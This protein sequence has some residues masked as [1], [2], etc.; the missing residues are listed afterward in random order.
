MAT[1][2]N[3]SRRTFINKIGTAIGGIYAFTS[4]LINPFKSWADNKGINSKTKVAATLADNYERTFIKQKV[5]HLFDSLG[6]ISDIIKPGFKVGIK[7]N[8]T[9]GSDWDGHANLQGVDIRECTWTHPEILRA[10]GELLLENG[11]S[12]EDIY[13]VEAIWDM[14]SYDLYGYKD[15]QEELGAQLVN[16]NNPDPYSDFM[17]KSTGTDYFF[18]PSLKLNKTL[19]ELEVFV[20]IPKMKQHYDA[21]LTHSM[22]NLVGIVPMHLY[23][24]PDNQGWRSKLHFEGGPVGQHLPSSICDLN[25]ARPIHLSVIDGIKNAV[26]GE[27]PW[28]DTFEPAEHGV[29]LAGKDPVATDSIAVKVMGFNPEDEK[30]LRPAGGY[31]D[32]HLYMMNQKGYGTNKMDEIELVGDG[33]DSIL[34]VDDGHHFSNALK[35]E[36]NYPN[37]FKNSTII[38]FFLP[39][40]GKAYIKIMNQSGKLIQTL[41]NERL[42]QGN[43]QV[44]WSPE[45]LP[46]GL[47]Y[48]RLQAGGYSQIRKMILQ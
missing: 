20:S 4:G 18:Y 21:A 33:A 7:I 6:G 8:L 24:M 5:R 34:S 16:L 45:N 39:V 27:G 29:L 38:D 19:D 1:K 47:Y 36:Q 22:K 26:G 10:V 48:C 42:P 30:I 25:M 44:N 41:V 2:N 46:A 9:G 13:I 11:V 32:N 28:N 37:P 40:S 31:A 35:L 3:Y 12:G 43:H 15:I 23:M 14:D 17:D